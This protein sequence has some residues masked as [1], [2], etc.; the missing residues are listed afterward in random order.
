MPFSGS[1]EKQEYY[2]EIATG[3]KPAEAYTATSKNRR[4]SEEK[5]TTARSTRPS[6]S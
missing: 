2:T 6:N 3:T 4:T 5:P 1:K